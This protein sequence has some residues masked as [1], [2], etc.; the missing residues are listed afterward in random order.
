M[1]SSCLLRDTDKYR[2]K[3]EELFAHDDKR[4]R[5]CRDC[6]EDIS[7]VYYLFRWT[8]E[9]FSFWAIIVDSRQN[10]STL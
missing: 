9:E 5:Y 8:A 6:E 1:E 7:R 10:A 3:E 2:M 4:P